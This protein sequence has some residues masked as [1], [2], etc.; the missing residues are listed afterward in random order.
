MERI[1]IIT[2]NILSEESIQHKLQ[3]MNYEVFTS[4]TLFDTTRDAFISERILNYFN[5]IIVSETLNNKEFKEILLICNNDD[6]VILRKYEDFV[7]KKEKQEFESLGVSG[8]IDSH[9]NFEM[10]RNELQPILEA[11]KNHLENH[12]FLLTSPRFSKIEGKV[13]KCIHSGSG[14]PVS[15]EKICELVWENGSTHSRM[16]SLS[17][18]VRRIREKANAAGLEG[19]AI[20]T[21]WGKGYSLSDNFENMLRKEVIGF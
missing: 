17:V 14:L 3:R 5:V 11:K 8:W 12:I 7:S 6:F 16:V 10:V 20:E 1:L 13:I 18:A 4:V 19:E 15:R 2:K 21:H 9:S